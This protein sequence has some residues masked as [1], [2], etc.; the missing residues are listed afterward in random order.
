MP[1]EETNEIYRH[2]A[3][4]G[5]IAFV[6]LE[7]ERVHDWA[8]PLLN[9][10]WPH[11]PRLPIGY[12]DLLL[13]LST[14]FIAFWLVVW[15]E[16]WSR[17]KDPI[18]I[19]KIK[20]HVNGRWINA[21][22]HDGIIVGASSFIISSS[23]ASERFTIDGVTYSLG[24]NPDSHQ[25]EV[26]YDARRLHGRFGSIHGHLFGEEGISY[27]F[28]GKRLFWR[29]KDGK[30]HEEQLADCEPVE[31]DRLGVAYYSFDKPESDQPESDKRIFL[32]GAF[33][34]REENSVS[35]VKGFRT[36][37]TTRFSIES[38]INA[39]LRSAEVEQFQKSCSEKFRADVTRLF[40]KNISLEDIR[41]KLSDMEK[42]HA[43]NAPSSIP[44][45]ELG[46]SK[47]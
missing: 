29:S 39:W 15:V 44:P 35:F 8:S 23:R 42:T 41:R 7:F 13:G 3:V 25:L 22:V 2:A 38:E 45:A 11:H 34:S 26:R 47:S 17:R 6:L 9:R 46:P 4:G 24:R 21:V 32:T 30:V 1:S 40:E 20:Q 28:T 5:A 43:R 33:L 18:V 31:E 10:I 37:A 27:P 36:A 19:P 14:A 16:R 12:V